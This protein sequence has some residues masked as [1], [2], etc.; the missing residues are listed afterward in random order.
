[1]ILTFTPYRGKFEPVTKVHKAEVKL[2]PENMEIIFSYDYVKYDDGNKTEDTT[3]SAHFVPR[4]GSSLTRSAMYHMD[5]PDRELCQ[6]VGIDVPG[7]PETIYLRCKN[8]KEADKIY[9]DLK[10]YLLM[11]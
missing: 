2:F 6:Y 1:M 4:Y 7:V 5:D 10:E 8:N 9:S 11:L 3:F